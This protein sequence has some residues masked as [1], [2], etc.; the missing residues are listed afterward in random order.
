MN[1]LDKIKS[2][3]GKK[4]PVFDPEL[5]GYGDYAGVRAE[6]DQFMEEERERVALMPPPP[7]AWYYGECE[8]CGA[9]RTLWYHGSDGPCEYCGMVYCEH[10]GA[11]HPLPDSD[12]R[13]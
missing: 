9:Q 8:C 6:I 3:F 7:S 5:Y 10:C 11:V 4:K 13:P 2:L 1:I 12:W